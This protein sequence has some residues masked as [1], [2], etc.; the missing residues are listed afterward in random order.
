MFKTFLLLALAA[1]SFTSAPA[2]KQERKPLSNPAVQSD[3]RP[4]YQK[5]LDEDVLYIL[6]AEERGAFLLLKSDAERERFIEQ[7]WRARDSK[8]GTSDNEYRAEHYRRIAY[9]NQ[10]LC[11]DNVPGG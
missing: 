11:A 1:L 4:V 8:P 9:A 5:W 3:L 6:S 10:P 2:Q 7:F